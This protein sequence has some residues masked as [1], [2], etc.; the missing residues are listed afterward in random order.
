M[1]DI[2]HYLHLLQYV[3][4]VLKDAKLAS[5]QH[6]IFVDLESYPS[7]K[8]TTKATKTIEEMTYIKFKLSANSNEYHEC[9]LV[10][11]NGSGYYDVTLLLRVQEATTPLYLG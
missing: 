10:L 1:M 6:Y 8:V 4:Y 7:E 5:L 3:L 2:L 9:A 11:N